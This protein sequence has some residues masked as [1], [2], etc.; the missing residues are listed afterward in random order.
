MKHQPSLRPPAQF[1]V[2]SLAAPLFLAIAVLLC[3]PRASAAEPRNYAFDGSISRQVLENYLS[4]SITMM[5]LLTGVG[6]PADNIR[7]LKDIGAKF[8][9]RTIYR[10]GGESGLPDILATARTLVPKVREAIPDMILQA[11]IFEIVSTDVEKLPIPA[12]VF[13]EF[14]LPVE[15]RNFRYEAMLFPNGRFRDHWTPGASVP[16]ISQQETRLWF[17]YLAAEYI[18]VGCESIHWGQVALIGANDPGYKHWWDVLSRARA[19]AKTHA[20]RHLLL[21]DAHTPDGG[22]LYDG[23]KLLFDAHAFPLRIED[24]LSK[25]QNGVLR[26]GYADSLY[27]RS[28]GGKTP[29]GWTCD[30]LPYLVELDNW[31]ASGKEGKHINEPWVWGYDEIGWFARQPETYRNDWLRYAFDWLREHDPNAFLEMP[32]SRCLAVPVEGKDGR[33]LS[34]YFANRPSPKVPTGFNQEDAIKAIWAE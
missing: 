12:Y 22:P 23:D 31:G 17:F 25:P 8:A 34:W 19:Y 2:H 14:G 5:D 16:D 18:N 15:Q 11:G 30:H 6:D 9:G 29:S 27:G 28:K 3:L 32:G 4:R 33:R 13:E 7:M 21:C 24:D 1:R 20:R 10:W 26:V